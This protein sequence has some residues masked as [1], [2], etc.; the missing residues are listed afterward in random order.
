MTTV[1]GSLISIALIVRTWGVNS[2]GLFG[3]VGTRAK[4]K[5]MSSASS[6]VPSWKRT[7]GRSFTSQVVASML[8]R[9]SARLGC[10]LASGPTS[11]SASKM[12]RSAMLLLVVLW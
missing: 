9:L 12:W 2:A 8:R 7:P 3:T 1:R 5:A 11:N 6:G 4:V 10:S